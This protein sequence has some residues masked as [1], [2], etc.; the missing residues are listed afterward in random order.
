MA[1]TFVAYVEVGEVLSPTNF[2]GSAIPIHANHPHNL[3]LRVC[4]KIRWR[5]RV[6]SVDTFFP[7][8]NKTCH[9]AARSHHFFRREDPENTIR[10]NKYHDLDLCYIFIHE[11]AQERCASDRWYSNNLPIMC[12]Y[13]TFP[14]TTYRPYPI[15]NR[16]S[17]CSRRRVT[18]KQPPKTFSFCVFP[19]LIPEIGL[20]KESSI[21]SHQ[22]E[23]VPSSYSSVV[24]KRCFL[25]REPQYP[26]QCGKDRRQH[27]SFDPC[28]QRGR[29]QWEQSE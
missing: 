9:H 2:S 4:F 11:R 29:W 5:R 28:E 13:T 25:P 16:A 21:V 18:K 12:R 24:L 22:H 10:G 14:T 7:P 20:Y 26:E 27:Q 19:I 15:E 8:A 3:I 23:L 6:L 1:P 17:S